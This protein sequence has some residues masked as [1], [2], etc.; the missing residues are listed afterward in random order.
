MK[1]C[2]CDESGT[3][4]EPIA[5]MVAVVVD[6]QRMH[7]TKEHWEHLLTQLSGITGRTLKEI[8]TRDFYSGNGAFRSLDGAKRSLCISAIFEW[9]TERKHHFIHSAIDKKLFQQKL[10]A[11]VIHN[12]INSIWQCLGFHTILAA[13][14]ALKQ[15]KGIKG[16]TIF[17]FDREVREEKNLCSLIQ[18][19]PS[20]SDTYYERGKKEPKLGQIIDV[21]YFGD[22]EEVALLQVA[23]FIAYFLRRYAEIEEGYSQPR[24]NDEYLKVSQ[25][26]KE[27]ANRTV[28]LQH[29][30]PKRKRDAVSQLF[31]EMCP[32]ALRELAS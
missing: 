29:I 12:E 31:Y 22:S 7:V 25:W 13:Q 19:P 5:V 10:D 8:H 26:V 16:H 23:D 32:K 2:Y 17:I 4:D 28:G 9:F 14:K 18:N 6:S 1:V 24:Y 3:G 21:P 11:G 15:E 30:Y 27:L 20:W